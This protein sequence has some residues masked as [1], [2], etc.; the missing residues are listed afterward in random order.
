MIEYFGIS[1]LAQLI[2]MII[3]GYLAGSI[4]F[5]LIL[6]KISGMGDVRTIGSGNIGATN[7]LRTGSKSL[8]FFVLILDGVKGF[9]SVI[10]GNTIS[11]EMGLLTGT[12]ALI[13]HL[14]PIWLLKFSQNKQSMA[15]F[16]L[17]CGGLIIALSGLWLF[18]ESIGSNRIP[19][20]TGVLG[21]IITIGISSK[22]W[23]GKGVATSLGILMAVSWQVGL[24][25]SI[26]WLITALVFHRSSLAAIVAMSLAPLW[27][28]ILSSTGQVYFILLNSLI[29]LLR[30]KDNISRLIQGKEPK[31]KFTKNS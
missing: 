3:L 5:G 25:V 24:V 15:S 31:I 2:T 10:I 19:I 8:A 22:A 30:H 9:I 17:K 7:V 16:L 11:P 26:T 21:G 1:L 23:G 29:I 13:G 12:A 28:L 14:F 6:T 20:W 4:P 18:Y 27:I